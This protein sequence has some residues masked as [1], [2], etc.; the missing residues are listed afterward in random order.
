M[1]RIYKFRAWEKSLREMIPV[2]NIDFESKLINTDGAWRMFHEVELMQYTGLNDRKRTTEYPEGQPIYEGDLIEVSCSDSTSY[3]SNGIHVVE[4]WN[5]QFVFKANNPYNEFD[6]IN[7][8]WW[9]KS[10]DGNTSLKQ[11]EV[12]GDKF[13]T[14]DLLP[15]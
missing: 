3:R 15:T 5:G 4:W 14:P 10:N 11:I 1:N 9:V 13:T 6:Y 12:I 7:F 2:H 8:G